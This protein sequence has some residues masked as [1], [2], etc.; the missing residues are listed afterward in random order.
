MPALENNLLVVFYLLLALAVLAGLSATLGK[1]LL[2]R[3]WRYFCV[4]WE[5]DKLVEA[6]TRRNADCRKRAEIELRDV[7][8]STEFQTPEQT[9]GAEQ[10][11]ETCVQKVGQKP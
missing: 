11:A 10:T 8:N 2:R 3:A 6:E 9:T 4:W 7:C 5:R 1:P